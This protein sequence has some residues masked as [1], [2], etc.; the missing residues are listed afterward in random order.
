MVH[1]QEQLFF[2]KMFVIRDYDANLQNSIKMNS[3]CYL[4]PL[5]RLSSSLKTQISV[6]GAVALCHQIGKSE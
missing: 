2:S 4:N 5:F 6:H 3:L 1:N